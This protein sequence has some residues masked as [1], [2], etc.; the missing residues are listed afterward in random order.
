MGELSE[1]YPRVWALSDDKFYRGIKEFTFFE[2]KATKR[3]SVQRE[4]KKKLP[5]FI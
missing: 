5:G 2:N 4:T 1:E 3:L